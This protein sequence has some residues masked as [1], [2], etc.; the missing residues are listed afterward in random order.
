[1]PDELDP[2]IFL[3]EDPGK[4]FWDQ[5]PAEMQRELDRV[6]GLIKSNPWIDNKV[7]FVFNYPPL[8]GILYNHP[9]FQILYHHLKERISVVAIWPAGT[10]S[11]QVIPRT[12]LIPPEYFF[13][14]SGEP[15]PGS[16]D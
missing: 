5:A 15:P 10:F 9:E 16:E 13:G 4:V 12:K 11:P 1:M 2:E 6:F 7:K 14:T 8:V 3:T